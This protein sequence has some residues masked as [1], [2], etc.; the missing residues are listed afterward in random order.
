MQVKTTS[1]LKDTVWR[2][3]CNWCPPVCLIHTEHGCRRRSLA[4]I[5]GKIKGTTAATSLLLI[6]Y[7]EHSIQVPL[8][9]SSHLIWT[10]LF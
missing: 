3:S 4:N 5:T 2:Y 1:D 7:F 9:N 6:H 8:Q 10:K